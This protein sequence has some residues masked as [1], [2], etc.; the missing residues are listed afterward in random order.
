MEGKKCE[1]WLHRG[2]DIVK[3]PLDFW[4]PGGL[5]WGEDRGP[6][7]SIISAIKVL[8]PVAR[9][10][11]RSPSRPNP[12]PGGAPW[13]KLKASTVRDRTRL[14]HA[15]NKMLQRSGAL[16]RSILAGWGPV[17]AV[18]GTNVPYARTHQFGAKKG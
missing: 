17:T 9:I 15:G 18:A 14:D 10:V 12:P 4:T 7:I 1:R 5:A 8:V 3:R 16:V 6:Q 11:P 2:V 13:P